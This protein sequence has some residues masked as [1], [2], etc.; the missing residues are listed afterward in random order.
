MT[1][2]SAEIRILVA[3]DEEVMRLLLVR[4]LTKK[5]YTVLVAQDGA[6]ARRILEKQH[7]DLLLTDVRMPQM[8]GMEVLR[9]MQEQRLKIPVIVMTAYGSIPAAIEA[10]KSGADNYITK[11]FER[12]E[13]LEVVKASLKTSQLARENL[14]LKGLLE[15]GRRFDELV[16]S[17]AKMR[18][19]YALIDAVADRDATVLIQG[20]SGVGKELVARSIHRRSGRRD[21]AFVAMHLGA[22]P[23]NL[24]AAELFGVVEGGFTGA[25]T[26]RRGAAQRAAGGTLFLDEI[27]DAPMVM[28]TALLRLLE[29][30]E[31]APVGSSVTET[32]DL[33][34]VAATNIDLLEAV[35]R[36]RF[37]KDLFYRLNVLAL[38]VPALRQRLDDLPDLVRHFMAKQGFDDGL[39]PRET[40]A[41]FETYGWPGN[42]RE[43]ENVVTRMLALSANGQLEAGLIPPEIRAAAL[44]AS[45]RLPPLKEAVAAF[46][47]DYL[48]ELLKATQGNVSEA[49]RRAGT[50]RPTLHAKIQQYRLRP[51]QFRA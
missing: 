36:G 41:I 7:V 46:E 2:D 49:A 22:V 4:I 11:P 24:V 47:S 34:I 31:V 3:D 43:L 45:R 51:D 27:G 29:Q 20:E 32:V 25:T 5:G 40:Q 17:A 39:F 13:I 14:R 33:R 35:E 6:E 21:G 16:G 48:A 37:R 15:E 8:G 44:D 50:S 1:E 9:W 38:Q 19:L 26:A 18:K 30:A 12:D 23:E 28:Q 10:L 42:V